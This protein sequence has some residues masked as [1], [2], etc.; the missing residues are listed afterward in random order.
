MVAGLAEK[1]RVG[2]QWKCEVCGV[3]APTER[4]LDEHLRG[5]RHAKRLK[6]LAKHL[7]NDSDGFKRPSPTPASPIPSSSPRHPI[8]LDAEGDVGKCEVCGPPG[9]TSPSSVSS[10]SSVE[11]P[12]PPPPSS[13]EPP[14]VQASS[15]PSEK[16]P[17]E[18]S[19]VIHHT[20]TTA[21]VAAGS[22]EASSDG[23]SAN[24]KSSS[25]R[26]SGSSKG[27]P[28]RII[29]K[30][31]PSG[32]GGIPDVTDGVV[33][34]GSSPDAPAAASTAGSTTTVPLSGSPPLKPDA[35]EFI[36]LLQASISSSKNSGGK[37]SSK[38]LVPQANLQGDK[39]TSRPPWLNTDPK[40]LDEE[41]R[42]FVRYL[43]PTKAERRMRTG[44]VTRLKKLIIELWPKCSPEV[45]GSY[46]TDLFIP[47]SDI[48]LCVKWVKDPNGL[49]VLAREIR[50]ARLSSYMNVIAKAKVPII[51]MLDRESGCRVDICFGNING[52]R[53]TQN[54]L[55]LLK[56]YPLARPLMLVIKY[57]IAQFGLNEVFT[58]GVGSYTLLL[59]IISF[60][61]LRVPKVTKKKP[62]EVDLGA[63]L[64]D[65]FEL[66]GRNFNYVNTGISVRGEGGYFHKYERG[67]Y[68]PMQPFC[69]CIED[70][71]DVENDVSRSSYLILDVRAVMLNA[72][73]A[74]ISQGDTAPSTLCRIILR[75]RKLEQTREKWSLQFGRS[76]SLDPGRDGPS[77][78]RK[79]SRSNKSTLST[80]DGEPAEKMTM[81][82][83]PTHSPRSRR[84][85]TKAK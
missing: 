6:K 7:R 13:V 67:W 45:F 66:Y 74:L 34:K 11:P 48:D 80:S 3:C 54:A 72:Y 63:L 59:M 24:G 20:T 46:A 55:K 49:F 30:D 17:K 68:N 53:N 57:Y 9:N 50:K 19:I 75:D 26:G 32:G 60:L 40:T 64:I 36:P 12:P 14:S 33:V 62:N 43:S 82:Q 8:D 38:P 73:Y 4:Q 18:D 5:R 42:K 85:G 71:D 39:Y 65:F 21:S 16:E 69:L 81:H 28:I 77:S 35:A 25:Y 51:K 41:I 70:P 15:P 10:K 2:D 58:G 44:V 22:S 29:E 1:V 56:Q 31:S 83:K 76:K 23:P 84:K 37:D 78:A 52:P 79:R 47:T 61:Q 27:S